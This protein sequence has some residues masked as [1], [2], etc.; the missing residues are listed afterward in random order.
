MVI[1]KGKYSRHNKE[2]SPGMLSHV[3]ACAY[4]HTS[5]ATRV[6]TWGLAGGRT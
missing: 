3:F 1:S 5:T 4:L 6:R 2:G